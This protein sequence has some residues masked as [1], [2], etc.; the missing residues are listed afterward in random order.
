MSGPL[1]TGPLHNVKDIQDMIALAKEWGWIPDV[2]EAER[3]SN[4]S[5]SRKKKKQEK[6]LELLN[7]M[8]E[9]SHPELPFGYIQLD[10]VLPFHPPLPPP[11][12]PPRLQGVCLR[13]L[14]TPLVVL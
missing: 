11:P 13:V 1:W 10:E 2:A 8:L 5:G 3:L 12:P 14:C 4:S 6:L 9:E 7:L